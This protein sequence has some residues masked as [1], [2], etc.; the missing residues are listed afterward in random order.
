MIGTMI[1]MGAALAAL[2]QDQ[3]PRAEPA[4]PPA[5]CAPARAAAAADALFSVPFRVVD[6]RIYVSAMVNGT[7]PHNFAVDTGASGM[8]R[9]D[10]ALVRDLGLSVTGSGQSSDG[11]TTAS[12]D[13]VRLASVELGG[14][15]RRD[16]DVITRDY[17]SRMSAD[18][19][20]AGILGRAFFEDGLLIIDYPA[21]RLTFTR[22]LSLGSDDPGVLRYERAFRVPVRIGDT[23]VQGNLDTGA[24]VAFVLPKPLFDR[25]DGGTVTAAGEGRLTNG[26]ISTGRAVMKGPF[27]IGAATLSDIEVRVSDRFPELLVGAYA[28]QHFTLLIDQRSSRVALCPA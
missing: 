1:R 21:R 8:G 9:A 2:V 14:L 26:S 22:A 25:I 23:V 3:P 19:A 27:R 5:A 4:A 6:G 7:G 16:I 20:F 17:A 15:V 10:A 13:T 28:L 11:V 12:V 24:N 18:A